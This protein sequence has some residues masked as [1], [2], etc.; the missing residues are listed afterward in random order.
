MGDDIS[1]AITADPAEAY[2]SGSGLMVG[3]TYETL[4]DY[5]GTSVDHVVPRIASKWEVPT[6]S[7]GNWVFHLNPQATFLDGSNVTA[8]D[9]VYSFDRAITLNLQPVWLVQFIGYKAGGAK[10]LDAHTVQITFSPDLSPD[11]IQAILTFPVTAIVSKKIC[12]QHA[13]GNDFGHKWVQT[14]SAGTGPYVLQTWERESRMVFTANKNYWGNKPQAGR[15]V[16]QH[17][18]ESETQSLMLQ[19]GDIDIAATITPDQATKLKSANFQVVPVPINGET[20]VG[21]N[22]GMDP[23]KDANVRKAVK[24]A[25]DYNGIIQKVVSNNAIFNQGIFPKGFVGADLKPFYTQ[26]QAQAKKL[27]SDAGHSSGVTVDFT[28]PAGTDSTGVKYS[29]IAAKVQNDLAAVGIKANIRQLENATL[30]QQYRAQKLQM[31]LASW[32]ADYADPAANASPFGDFTAKE[33]AYRL[34]WKDQPIIDLVHQAAKEM[35][36]T[37]RAQLYTQIQQQIEDRG[38]YAILYQPTQKYAISPKIKNFVVNP[39]RG[40]R[41]VYLTK[42]G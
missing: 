34:E 13:Q 33:L 2:E 5:E 12:Q 9:V 29:D 41:F 27:L 16:V 6:D 22:A 14:N 17:V 15:V 24:L 11:I 35:D 32:G 40:L 18:P 3:Q 4:V 36:H 23:F 8:D 10:A 7:S 26:D 28:I 31:V 25:I 1:E 20:Y 19:S 39:Q 37:K 38:V 21:M 42:E 30:Y